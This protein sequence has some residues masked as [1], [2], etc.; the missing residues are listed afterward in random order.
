MCIQYNKLKVSYDAAKNAG[1]VSFWGLP[2]DRAAEFGWS[3]AILLEDTRKSYPERRYI[4]VGFLDG[5]LHVL[6]FSETEDGIRVIS[7]R[8]ANEREIKRHAKAKNTG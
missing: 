1:N 3:E 5:R 6:C 2:F 8:K 7:F 4:A